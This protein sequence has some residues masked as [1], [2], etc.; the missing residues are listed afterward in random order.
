MIEN[1]TKII[2][3]HVLKRW[4]ENKPSAQ[5]S[6]CASNFSELLALKV[7]FIEVKYHSLSFVT[8]SKSYEVYVVMLT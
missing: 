8:Y 3:T 2:L 4:N 5:P 1:T 7:Y 6:T